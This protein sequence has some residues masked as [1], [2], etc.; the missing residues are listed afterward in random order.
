VVEYHSIKIL[1]I[2]FYSH[3]GVIIYL[4]MQHIFRTKVL[5]SERFQVAKGEKSCGRSKLIQ[6]HFR[7]NTQPQNLY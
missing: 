2:F 4:K 6:V 7:I 1:G 5:L 3:A